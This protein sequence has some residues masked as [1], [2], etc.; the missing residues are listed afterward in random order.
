MKWPYFSS[1]EIQ[2]VVSVIKSG[3][4]NYWTGN[5]CKSFERE[6]AKYFGL[7][8]CVS[9]ANAS[10]GLEAAVL[11]LKLKSN[12]EVITTSR[13]YCSTATSIIRAGSKV[14]FADINKNTQN[15]DPKSIEEKITKNTKAIIC[16][17]LGGMPCNLFE[18][19]KITKKYNLF[20]IEDCS[21]SHGAKYYNKYVGTYGD[22][23]VWSFCN[24]KIIS[25]LGEGGMV[26][27]K[28]K[29]LF[30]RIWSAKDIGKDFKKS[31]TKKLN[32]FKWIHDNLGT[33]MR[34]TEAQ[35][36]VGRIQLKKLDVNVKKRRK[37]AFKL[38]QILKS[39]SLFRPIK[40]EYGYYNSYYK[41]YLLLNT[42]VLKKNWNREKILFHLNKKGIF[43]NVGSCPEIYKEKLFQ[44]IDKYPRLKNAHSL[45]KI[46]I[47]ISLSHILSQRY[48]NNIIET[49]LK[50]EKISKNYN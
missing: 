12:D 48:L 45:G 24:D 19:K 46:S 33:N 15:I 14:V 31:M 13:S 20:L 21:Q 34:L 42:K 18:I 49:L 9:V 6:F 8:Y 36:A 25:T 47:A 5:E 41:Y 16:V 40:E 44:K 35:A 28:N 30:E 23:S 50:I 32:K 39:S 43:A 29:K 26:S 2:K 37:I 27:T 10:L 22:I 11:S 4:I 7:K 3:N 1:K 38:D 17:H